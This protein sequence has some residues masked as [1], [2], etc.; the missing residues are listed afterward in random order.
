MYYFTTIGP[1]PHSQTPASLPGPSLTPGPQ[2]ST[3]RDEK[4]GDGLGTRLVM[5]V[6]EESHDNQ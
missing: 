3:A 5:V 4:L 1:Q 2:P 6:A